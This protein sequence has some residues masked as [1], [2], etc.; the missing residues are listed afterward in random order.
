MFDQKQVNRLIV[1]S[2]AS[3]LILA[4]WTIRSGG[5]VTFVYDRFQVYFSGQTRVEQTVELQVD[6]D[7]LYHAPRE[8]SSKQII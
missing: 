3:I 2:A 6:A 4:I 8:K 7:L 1:L 5:N